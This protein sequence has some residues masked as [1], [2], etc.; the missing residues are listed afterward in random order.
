MTT[1][2]TLARRFPTYFDAGVSIELQ[3]SPGLGK[4]ELVH[5]MRAKLS[6]MY[7]EPIGFAEMMLATQTPVDLLGFM[8]PQDYTYGDGRKVLRSGFTEPL[9]MT[10]V[11]GKSVNEYRRGILFLDEYGQGE[12]EVK[13]ASAELLL[14]KRLG[15]HRLP[16][17]WIVVAAS[18]RSKDRSGV[19]K[20]FDFVIN[21][22]MQIEITP[23]VESWE[24]WAVDHDISPEIVAF[25][26]T[27]PSIV[28]EADVPKE[29][30]PWCTPRSLVL[31]DRILSKFKG[32]DGLFPED[33]EAVEDAQG[34]IGVPAAAQLFAT[35]RLSHEMPKYRE[36]LSAPSKAKL[37]DRPD[38]RM[39]VAYTLANRVTVEDIEPVLTY[40]DRLPPEFSVTFAKA[41]IRKTFSLIN[42]PIMGKWCVKHQ[43]LMAAIGD[44][45]R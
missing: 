19:T 13:R 39:L 37:P 3:S 6:A 24:E 38:G 8:V 5:Q 7:N 33:A 28:F 44:I 11:D 20:S 4:S 16:E 42:T 29:Q 18:N 43:G 25:A 45:N 31:C 27:N 21:R 36:I 17:G 41:A 40:V 32:P 23:D 14:N 22:R 2:K 10:C 1:L 35:I 9:W 12:P 34:M 15:P 26:V 30:G